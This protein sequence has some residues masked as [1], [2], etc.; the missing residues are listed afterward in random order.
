MDADLIWSLEDW[1]GDLA[2]VDGDLAHDRALETAT[3]IS[4]FSDRRAL[5]DDALPDAD[6][7]W[8]GFESGRPP[9]VT[10]RRGWWADGSLPPLSQGRGDRIGSRIWLLS[11]E[12]WTNGT[13]ERLRCYAEEALQWLIEDG[14]ADRVRVQAQRDAFQKI[15]L[16][17]WIERSGASLWSGRFDWSWAQMFDRTDP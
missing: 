10:G 8:R 16:S 14:I 4:L 2:I 13:A 11:R 9:G 3:L 1:S 7:C 12:K 17:I 15:S 5:P 6:S